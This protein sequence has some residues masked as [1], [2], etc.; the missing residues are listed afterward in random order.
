[1]KA[2]ML[3]PVIPVMTR[4]PSN[5]R[6]N[7]VTMTIFLWW[8]LTLRVY[9]QLAIS[10]LHRGVLIVAT[11]QTRILSLCHSDSPEVK[12]AG[13]AIQVHTEHVGMKIAKPA[14]SQQI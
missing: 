13:N 9:V 2:M 6:H 7:F 11:K 5:R 12:N 4:R 1:M 10:Q 8:E 3:N 14:I